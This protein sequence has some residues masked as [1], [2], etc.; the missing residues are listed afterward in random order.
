S[1]VAILRTK[2]N[3]QHITLTDTSDVKP[4]AHCPNRRS[5]TLCLCLGGIVLKTESAEELIKRPTF[6][7]NKLR[8]VGKTKLLS[9][10]SRDVLRSQNPDLTFDP[11]R[12]WRPTAQHGLL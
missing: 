5:N 7:T 6:G 4:A 12:I 1:H 3:L 11:S 10:I 9:H 8:I 2:I